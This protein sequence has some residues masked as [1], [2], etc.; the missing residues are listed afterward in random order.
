M[1]RVREGSS[2]RWGT[3]RRRGTQARIT[4][5][6]PNR[7]CNTVTTSALDT[8]AGVPAVPSAARAR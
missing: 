8:P 5:R 7:N 6:C 4:V 1:A 3:G 2:A